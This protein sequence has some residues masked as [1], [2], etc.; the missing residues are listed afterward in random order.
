[1]RDLWAKIT[2]ASLLQSIRRS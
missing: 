1:V 2:I